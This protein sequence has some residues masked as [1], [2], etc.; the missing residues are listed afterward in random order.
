MFVPRP[1]VSFTHHFSFN[2]VDGAVLLETFV[3]DFITTY[4]FASSQ[5][6]P[7]LYFFLILYHTY[8]YSEVIPGSALRDHSK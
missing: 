7:V 4:S 1:Q 5:F 8:L 3:L 6:L 2:T